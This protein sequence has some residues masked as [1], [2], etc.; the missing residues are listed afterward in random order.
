MPTSNPYMGFSIPLLGVQ[1]DRHPTK[2]DPEGLVEAENCLYRD[3]NFASRPGLIAFGA[4]VGV[5]SLGFMQY[6]DPSEIRRVVQGTTLGWLRW[7][8]ATLAWVSITDPTNGLTGSATS[9]VIFRVF[10]QAGIN[11]VLGVNATNRAK[12]WDSNIAHNY[13]DIAGETRVPRCIGVAADHV[14]LGG[15]TDGP[16]EIEA[17]NNTDFTTGYSTATHLKRFGETPGD[18][19]GIVEFGDFDAV[20]YKTDA[21]Y[22]ATPLSGETPFAY[23]PKFLG[24]P[25]PV[26]PAAIV[27]LPSGGH[28]AL[29]EDGSVRVFTGSDFESVGPHIQRFVADNWLYTDRAQSWGYYDELRRE[30]WFIYPHKAT[31]ALTHGICL[32]VPS[33]ALYP[34]RWATM[35]MTA[36]GHFATASEVTIGEIALPLGQVAQS[37]GSFGQDRRV[38]LLGSSL[39][40]VCEPAGN[41]D[42]G[43]AIPG[44]FEY[45]LMGIENMT[46]WKTAVCGDHGFARTPANQV[47]S[48][49]VGAVVA[50]ELRTMSPAATINLVG[51]GPLR[52]DHRTT[53][54]MLTLRYEWSGLQPVVFLGSSVGYKLLGAR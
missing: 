13:A 37:I 8:K 42:L 29:C 38:T 7:D 47:V 4:S 25:G 24:L 27:K 36:G 41:D 30:L 31:G 49:F 9:Q 28:A 40:Q 26:S 32:S 6:D 21:I 12:S 17:S 2:V 19:V 33:W 43:A 1:A 46:S 10:Q 35:I 48:V 34:V 11:Y 23:A 54:R 39:G 53:G 14:L 18:V 45:G 50:G 15:F 16:Q 22:L 3:G 51:A 5:R 44:L 52:T 20:V